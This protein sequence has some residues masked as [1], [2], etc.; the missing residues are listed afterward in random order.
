MAVQLMNPEGLAEVP[1][2]RHVAIA[3]GSRQVYLAGQVATDAQGRLVGEGDL[4]AQVE[5]CFANVATA[6]AAAGATFDDVVKVTAYVVGW[7]DE[8]FPQ[9][10]EGIERGRARVGTSA[11]PPLTG[12]GVAALADP[13]YLVELDVTA[14]LT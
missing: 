4:P 12:I 14:V 1:I 5:Q 6:L 3:T 2:Y 10:V 8:T 9:A 13:R 7:S 11:L